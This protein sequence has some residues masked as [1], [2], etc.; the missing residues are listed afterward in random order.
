LPISTKEIVTLR[1]SGMSQSRLPKKFRQALFNRYML[2][3]Q[4]IQMSMA[5]QNL[6]EADVSLPLSDEIHVRM[7]TALTKDMLYW[8]ILVWWYV[9]RKGKVCRIIWRE[10]DEPSL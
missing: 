2:A 6:P 4:D 10:D 5:C 8:D 3:D 7:E 9:Q 1:L